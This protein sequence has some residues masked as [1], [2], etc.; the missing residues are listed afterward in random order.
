VA[1]F[2]CGDSSSDEDNLET[3][4]EVSQNATVHYSGGQ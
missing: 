1:N 2:L 4:E 3:P